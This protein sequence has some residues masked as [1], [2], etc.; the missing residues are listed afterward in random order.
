MRTAW[1]AFATQGDPGWPDYD[2]QQRLTQLFDTQPTVTTYPERA[3]R[4]IWQH[5]TFTAL[6]L[7]NR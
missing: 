3:S 2:T 5:H 7:I 4:L 6:P 1:T